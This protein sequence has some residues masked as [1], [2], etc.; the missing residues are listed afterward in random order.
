MWAIQAVVLGLPHDCSTR[1][2]GPVCCFWP[3][4]GTYCLYLP[5][6]G[7]EDCATLE[8]MRSALGLAM[9]LFTW[10]CLVAQGE[11]YQEGDVDAFLKGARE[12]GRP[13]IV[14]FNFDAKSG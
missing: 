13:A 2:L 6:E 11:C 7:Q 12:G 4:A 5:A 10:S 3:C 9:C 14:L 1:S 8:R